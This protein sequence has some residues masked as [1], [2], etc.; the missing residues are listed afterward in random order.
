MNSL[1]RITMV[2]VFVLALC[3]MVS[4]E[5]PPVMNFQGR[6][7]QLSGEPVDNGTYPMTFAIYDDATGGILKWTESQPSITVE[8]GIFNVILGTV[9]PLTDD[10]FSGSSAYI[11]VTVDGDIIEPRTQLTSAGYAFRIGTVDGATAGTIAGDFTIVPAGTQNT[12]FGSPLSAAA[13]TRIAFSFP[14]GDGTLSFYEPIDSRFG[15]E[16][17]GKKVVITNDGIVM[18]GA[19]D[20]D[21]T[22]IVAPNGD[23]IGK[24]QITMGENS[25]AGIETVVLGYGNT[26][27]GDSSTIGGGSNNYTTGKHSTI[28]G[29]NSNTV[30]GDGGTIG[31][32]S[33]NTVDG[34]YA[35]IAGGYYNQALGAYSTIPGGDYNA[36]AGANSFAAGHRAKADHDGSYVWADHTDEDFI[37]TAA[38]QY[39]IRATGGVGIGTNNPTGLLEVFGSDG[40]LSVNLPSSAIASPEILD[41]PGIAA[42]YTTGAFILTQGSAVTEELTS[43]TITIP[44]AGYISVRGTTTLESTGTNKQNQA[45]LQVSETSGGPL[46]PTIFARAGSGDHDTPSAFHYFN[47]ET[48]RIFMKA[49]GTYTFYL[50]GLAAQ[51]NGGS[52]VAS[53]LNSYIVA[54]YMPTSYGTVQTIVATAESNLF[55]RQ[56]RVESGAAAPSGSDG[57]AYA[58]D[59]RELELKAMKAQVEAEKAARELLEYKLNQSGLTTSSTR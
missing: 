9:V 39:L 56:M 8:D 23:I 27:D 51:D 48:E 28:S 57:S 34:L 15:A 46:E 6:L 17:P 58:V 53:L 25:S 45:Y 10:V 22:L 19:T 26:A 1:K 40:D 7:T 32:G 38:D 21:T 14:A 41:E 18:F 35:T 37:S 50:N 13:N 54:T 47:L 30:N 33:Y 24:G 44:A 11:Q 52:A 55:D 59:L 36:A 5:V 31:G 12:K 42:S 2:T 16:E 4:A 43:V 3:I 20:A 29:G 49:A